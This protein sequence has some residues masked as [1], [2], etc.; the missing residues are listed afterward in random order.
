MIKSNSYEKAARAS[1][2]ETNKKYTKAATL[3][4]I[5]SSISFP[6]THIFTNLGYIAICVMGGVFVLEGRINIGNVQAFLQYVSR[7]NRPITEIASTMATIQA[8][9]AA[10]ERVF[11]FLAE[12]EE[13]PDVEPSL[14]ID[15][16]KGE[17]VFDHVNFGYL[18]GV[19]VIKNFS[20]RVC[21]R[22]IRTASSSPRKRPT[23]P[24]ASDLNNFRRRAATSSGGRCRRSPAPSAVML[25]TPVKRRT[26]NGSS[27]HQAP[28]RY[29]GTA[30]QDMRG[31]SHPVPS[32]R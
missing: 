9:L 3:A 19:P 12:P 31:V 30:R 27:A 8:L 24:W 15:D 5:F 7:F 4:Q 23:T 25:Y 29:Q 13:K 32:L 21:A 2:D 6:A 11:E 16:I 20:A 17:V 18:P 28:V 22:A 10:S 14:T 1:F 26:D